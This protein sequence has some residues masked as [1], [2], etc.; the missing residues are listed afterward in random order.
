MNQTIGDRRLMRPS[1]ERKAPN[2]RWRTCC[3]SSDA[4]RTGRR[5]GDDLHS[6]KY[7]EHVGQDTDVVGHEQ[8]GVGIGE[9]AQIAGEGVDQ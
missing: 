9:G 5:P 3:S 1:R 4:N 7:G 6:L 2:A 8:G